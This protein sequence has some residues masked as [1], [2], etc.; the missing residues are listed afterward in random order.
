MHQPGHLAQAVRALRD[1]NITRLSCVGGRAL[2]IQLLDHDLIDDLYLT[3]SPRP[4]G[5]PGTPVYDK[6]LNGREVV[7]KDGT[8]ADAGVVFQHIVLSA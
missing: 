7:R 1:L 3:T 6:P 8:G 2:A 5:E 4:G